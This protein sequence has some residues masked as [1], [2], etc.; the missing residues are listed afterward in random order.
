MEY[1]IALAPSSECLRA[2]VEEKIKEGWLPQGGIAVMFQQPGVIG[3]YQ[4]MIK[5][6]ENAVHAN[7]I[8]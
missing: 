1:T 7:K 3:Y 8:R 4:A 5:E 6:D 2:R